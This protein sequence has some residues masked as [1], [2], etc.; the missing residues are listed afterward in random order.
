MASN[1]LVHKYGF[2]KYSI[3]NK[4]KEIAQDLFGMENKDRRLLQDIGTKMR[5]LKP[6]IWAD[7]LI[8]QL[9]RDSN[10]PV[11]S[12]K[13]VVI[14]EATEKALRDVKEVLTL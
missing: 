9:E 1:H 12:S 7:Y 13:R 10:S 11:F 14:D 8:R 6:T 5:D 3:G 4:I 2:V